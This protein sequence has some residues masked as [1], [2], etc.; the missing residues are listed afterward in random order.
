METRVIINS[1]TGSVFS[2]TFIIVPCLIVI[3]FLK[4]RLYKID[5]QALIEAANIILLFGSLLYLI[6]LATEF[7]VAFYSQTEY[8]QYVFTNRYAGS[9]WY[10]GIAGPI[11]KILLPQILWAKKLR[12]S[13]ALLTVIFSLWI[14]LHIVGLLVM[15]FG[16]SLIPSQN[17]SVG[18]VYRL[19]YSWKDLL[20][21]IVILTVTYFILKRKSTNFSLGK[22]QP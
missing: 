19:S 9:L 3:C 11:S 5:K 1:I 15:I 22:I 12:K 16:S 10:L 17:I 2:G 8:E 13:L 6:M 21:Y 7:F 4:I 14:V 18:V 20:I